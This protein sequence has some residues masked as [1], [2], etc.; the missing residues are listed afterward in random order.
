VTGLL[1]YNMGSGVLRAVGD[2]R[3]PLYFLVFSALTNTALDLVFVIYCGWG[4]AGV[5]IATIISQFLSAM[6]VLFVLTRTTGCYRIIW[7]RIRVNGAILNKIWKIGMPSALQQA[8]T[9][10]SNVF[11]QSYINQFGSACMAGWSSY[12]KL[13][14]FILLPMQSMALAATTFVG[15]NLGANNVKRAKTGTAIAVGLSLAITAVLIAPLMIFA[16][17]MISLFNTDPEVLEYGKLFILTIS[18]FYVLCVINQVYAGS[19]RGAGDTTASMIIMLTSF[20]VCRQ[21]YLFVISRLID[22]VIPVALGYPLGWLLA[23]IAIFI[24]YRQG[25][26]EKR[27]VVVSEIP[28]VPV[29]EETGA[30]PL[31][32]E[33]RPASHQLHI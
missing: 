28:L 3:R 15:Q 26:W 11:V 29:K 33:D 30:A 17:Q 8:I 25:R 22:S 12:A 27:R 31:L 18:P 7:N 9:S 20:V 13:D 19:L 2:S 16:R 32:T 10:F 5:A 21:I 24:Y 1:I 4:I 23:S 6:L 14:Q